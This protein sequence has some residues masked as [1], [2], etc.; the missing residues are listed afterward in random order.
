MRLAAAEA[1]R[2][3]ATPDGG[4]AVVVSGRCV[5]T[6]G[7]PSPSVMQRALGTRSLSLWATQLECALWR[8]GIAGLRL[9]LA[10][11]PRADV[12]SNTM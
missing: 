11:M 10:G 5:Q 3:L 7:C 4:I 1:G 2:V 9:E 12:K 6:R 8:C